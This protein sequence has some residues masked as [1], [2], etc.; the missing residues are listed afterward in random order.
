MDK[1][2]KSAIWLS[3]RMIKRDIALLQ[4]RSKCS[5]DSAKNMFMS[6]IS[7]LERIAEIKFEE[8]VHI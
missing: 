8:I 4:N 5:Y 3:Y 6:D 7:E 1:R 2:L